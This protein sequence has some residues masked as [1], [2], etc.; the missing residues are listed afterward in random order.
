MYGCVTFE[1]MH[2]NYGM[3]GVFSM[4]IFMR[5]MRIKKSL[6]VTMFAVAL[7]IVLPFGIHGAVCNAS[8][9]PAISKK[10]IDINAGCSKKIKVKSKVSG[11]IKVSS[12][13]KTVATVRI[14]KKTVK[15]NKPAAFVVKGNNPG[16]AVISVDVKLKKAV[17]NKKNFKLKLR[18]YVLDKSRTD[19]SDLT[20]SSSGKGS[21]TYSIVSQTTVQSSN[22]SSSKGTGITPTLKPYITPDCGTC[23]TPAITTTAPT[24]TT[25][26]TRQPLPTESSSTS[27]PS[28]A[29]DTG[30]LKT[31]QIRFEPGDAG[32]DNVKGMPD[33]VWL[34]PYSN[35]SVTDIIPQ[36]EGHTFD[37]WVL[38]G[39]DGNFVFH[40]GDSISNL[41][42]SIG[43]RAIWDGKLPPAGLPTE[44]PVQTV[45]PTSQPTQTVKPTAQPAQ[46][47]QPDETAVYDRIM[48]MQSE[49]P[50]GMPW[51]NANMY[52]WTVL[53]KN[54]TYHLGGCAAFA[55][56]LSDAGFGKTAPARQI[57][58]PSADIVRIGDILR[59]NNNTHS[60]IVI[61][62]DGDKFTIAEG[63]YNSSIN[64]G[65]K[66]PKTTHIDFIWT[67]W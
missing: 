2:Y 8:A 29:P 60:V 41:T 31:V 12:P 9:K 58:N 35:Y 49:Y 6:A 66:I 23:I 24:E 63:N 53:G 32:W 59:I 1:I 51:T 16:Y 18:V 7:S 48:A 38:T 65:R 50:Q 43:F 44:R 61:G 33:N 3:E 55:C 22:S 4:G 54:T 56:I 39:L 17:N 47:G 67:R 19:N 10:N 13:N 25:T 21:G 26:P 52:T 64:W 15:N 20:V 36:W 46:T 30:A 40:A 14:Q 42:R 28:S 11:S 57:D 62:T 27:Q 5:N 45:N 37:G 34:E